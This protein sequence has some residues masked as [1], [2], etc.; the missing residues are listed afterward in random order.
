MKITTEVIQK[1]VDKIIELTTNKKKFKGALVTYLKNSITP[2]PS[3]LHFIVNHLVEGGKLIV[4]EYGSIKIYQ[5]NKEYEPP[6]SYGLSKAIMD[7]YILSRTANN[8]KTIEVKRKP[9]IS[10]EKEEIIKVYQENITEKDERIFNASVLPKRNKTEN[11]NNISKAEDGIKGLRC[12]GLLKCIE[13]LTDEEL[14]KEI[15]KRGF[16]YTSKE[17]ADELRKQGYEVT[18]TKTIVET[19]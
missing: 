13:R 16:T 19:L 2:A 8:E 10:Q 11:N 12:I 7:S 6:V 3:C 4:T 15:R 5:W 18:A 14:S 17:L 9:Y 1:Y